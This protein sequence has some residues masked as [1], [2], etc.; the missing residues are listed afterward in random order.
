MDFGT[1][2][3]AFG[4]FCV[5]V[6]YSL[7][8]GAVGVWKFAKGKPPFSVPLG[9][10]CI[11]CAFL[12]FWQVCQLAYDQEAYAFYVA[13]FI[14]IA[15]LGIVR[16]VMADNEKVSPELNF[17]L[18]LVTG[19]CMLNIAMLRYLLSLIHYEATW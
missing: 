5:T 7:C 19:F 17:R 12:H 14:A 9:I 6:L 11:S 16:L 1:P 2:V 15:I 13:S 4:A 8:A 10:A 18:F 3:A